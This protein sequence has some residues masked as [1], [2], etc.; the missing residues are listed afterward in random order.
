MGL[1]QRALET[2]ESHIH[3]TEN[4]DGV[5]A[6]APVG[7]IV[8]RADLEITLDPEG[9]FV[10]ASAVD[11]MEPKIIIPVTEGSAGRTSAPCPHP[12]CEQLGYLLAQ[13]ETKYRLYTEQL[14]A[15][16]ASAWSSSGRRT[17]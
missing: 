5:T 16:E 1:L 15:W 12:L 13:N 17:C 2:Y 11:K 7:H 14:A 6:M 3:Y 4:R 9:R 8:T 10:I